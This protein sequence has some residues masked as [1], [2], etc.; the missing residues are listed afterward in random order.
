MAAFVTRLRPRQLPGEIARQLPDL[1]TIIWVD[2]S[3][4][5]ETRH[6]GALNKPGWMI[7]QLTD[8]R[9]QEDV[10]HD[11]ASLIR[12][13]VLLAAQGWR[14]HDD[15]DALRDDPAFRLAVSSASG[16]T[17]LDGSH[18]LASQPTLSRF[19]AIMGNR[20]VSAD[21]G[22]DGDVVGGHRLASA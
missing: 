4:T 12:T 16:C 21:L 15:A 18:G 10:V 20:P 9:R 19:T 3:S 1:S 17:P 11:L 14:D 22:A 2:P 6:R 5:G 7:P 8:P 13:S